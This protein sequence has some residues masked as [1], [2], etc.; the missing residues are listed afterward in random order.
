MTNNAELSRLSGEDISFNG[1]TK[2]ETK[3]D[4]LARIKKCLKEEVAFDQN[5]YNQL[6]RAEEALANL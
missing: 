2:Q 5:K 3:E 1:R 6:S 4:Y